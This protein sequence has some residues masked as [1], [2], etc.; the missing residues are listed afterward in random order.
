MGRRLGDPDDPLLVSVRSGAKFSMPGMMETVL[1]VG[2]NDECV[3]GLAA[4]ADNPRFA[5]DSY[6]RLIQMFGKTVLDI[7]GERFE[8]ALEAPK[9]PRVSPA[10]SIWAPPTWSSSSR[11]Y[12]A[13]VREHTGREFPQDPRA[14]LDRRS[15]R[16]S[17]PGTPTAPCST[18]ARS[19][20]PTTW[21]PR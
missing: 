2:L 7:E 4:Q 21:A 18:A 17:P 19:A 8:H 16:C 9:R 6:R 11:A 1:N 3:H 14:Q 10:T 15:R 20:S 5:W 13:L 12:K